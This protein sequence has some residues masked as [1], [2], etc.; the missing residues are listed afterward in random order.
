MSAKYGIEYQTVDATYLGRAEQ[1]RRELAQQAVD[2]AK[3]FA[4]ANLLKIIRQGKDSD[5]IR[6]LD[7]LADITGIKAPR[8]I[9]VG[10]QDG[11]PLPVQT[12]VVAIGVSEGEMP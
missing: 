2:G 1:R 3:D 9:G 7:L 8:K 10:D 11:N 12:T 6:A 5:K 4:V